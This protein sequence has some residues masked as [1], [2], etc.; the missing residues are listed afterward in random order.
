MQV[1]ETVLFPN[2]LEILTDADWIEMRAGE[3]EIGW[4]L[5][6]APVP[7]PKEEYVHP[8][9]D[10]TQ[11]EMTFS[12]ENTTHYDEGYMTVEQVNL[13]L[14][15]M[16]LDITYVDENDKVIFYNRGEERVFPRS[17]G[18]IGR[19]SSLLS[20]AEKCGNRAWKFW[21]NLEKANK[22]NRLSGLITKNV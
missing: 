18:I 13:L 14:K 10:F 20:S 6:K 7:Y 8:S 3:E 15:T 21:I 12:L 16:P 11:R 9:Q 1:E 5:S 17:A 22:M 19:G 2:A 4:M